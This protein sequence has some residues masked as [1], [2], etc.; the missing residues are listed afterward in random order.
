MSQ[1]AIRPC[2][3][4][5]NGY[6]A[7][8]KHESRKRNAAFCA[9]W[10]LVLLAAAPAAWS[11]TLV[12]GGD[13]TTTIVSVTQKKTLFLGLAEVARKLPVTVRSDAEAGLFVLCTAFDCRPVYGIDKA[14]CSSS[15]AR[16]MCARTR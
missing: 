12:W 11:A 9:G 13:S 7:A 5:E 16:P 3:C 10:L 4:L 2:N 14:N 8:M 15:T 6:L 1:A